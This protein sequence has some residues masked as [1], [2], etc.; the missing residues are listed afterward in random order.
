MPDCGIDIRNYPLL[1]P[2]QGNFIFPQGAIE[3]VKAI[4]LQTGCGLWE[5][6]ILF[7]IIHLIETGKMEVTPAVMQG[8][9][10]PALKQVLVGAI[11]LR[12]MSGANHN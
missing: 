5:A 10:D 6:V 3:R 11:C 7:K 8:V 4:R 12:Q 9:T 1:F 2:E